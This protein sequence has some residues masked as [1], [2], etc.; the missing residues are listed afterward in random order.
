[1]H[2][3]KRIAKHESVC[4]GPL[5]MNTHERI[6]KTSS[7]CLIETFH[8]ERFIKGDLRTH[9]LRY[10]SRKLADYTHEHTRARTR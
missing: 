7:V 5:E 6:I 8:V 9:P 10:P 4:R 2:A 3:Q 1:M